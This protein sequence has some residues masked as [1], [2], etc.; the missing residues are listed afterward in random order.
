MM[1]AATY[2]QAG[3]ITDKAHLAGLLAFASATTNNVSV[4]V[5]FSSWVQKTDGTPLALGNV[6]GTPMY[7]EGAFAAYEA[8]DDSVGLVM[9]PYDDGAQT[10]TPALSDW[11]AYLAARAQWEAG[12]RA[13]KPIPK[14]CQL[15]YQNFLL[16]GEEVPAGKCDSYVK[17]DRRL[18]RNGCL[19]DVVRRGFTKTWATLMG[20]AANNPYNLGMYIPTSATDTMVI[21]NFCTLADPNNPYDQE[22]T[23]GILSETYVSLNEVPFSECTPPT[24]AAMC[25][26][27][28]PTCGAQNAIDSCGTPRVIGCNTCIAPLS[29]FVLNTTS[30]TGGA[31]RKSTRL[32]SSHN[33]ASRMPSSA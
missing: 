28:A 22:T 18:A 29:T 9:M 26:G 1:G 11:Q 5:D 21:D 23:R 15:A 17:V 32:N 20:T 13:T 27:L 8:F 30:V 25:A 4:A 33:P 7:M 2:L 31:D 6:S 3:T 10:V 12:T 16:N 24:A 14:R 19:K